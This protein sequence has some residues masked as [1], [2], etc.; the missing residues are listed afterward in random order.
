MER[1]DALVKKVRAPAVLEV[2]FA[3]SS[4]RKATTKR[5]VKNELQAQTKHIRSA[6]AASFR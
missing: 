5:K 1:A 6:S 2:H 4:L 3:T